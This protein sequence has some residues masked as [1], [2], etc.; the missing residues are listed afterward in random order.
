MKRR[1]SAAMLALLMSACTAAPAPT[2]SSDK[3]TVAQPLREPD[4]RYEPSPQ[5]VVRAM[6]EL[7]QVKEGDL[8]YDLGSGDGRIPI[9]A[10]RE[11][12]ARAVGI[13]ID[14]ELVALARRNAAKAGLGN[15]VAFINQDMFE[16]DLSSATVV[17]L[18]LYPDVNLKLRPKLKSE[19]RPGTRVVSHWHDMADWAPDQTITVMD[20]PVYLWIIR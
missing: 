18:F 11:H 8:L 16:T 4:V 19:L 12:G 1:A 2:A 6:L 20:R 13:E 14:P 5:P 17:T 9:T 3:P 10:A 7:A 15:R